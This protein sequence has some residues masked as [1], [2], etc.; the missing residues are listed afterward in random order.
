MDSIDIAFTTIIVILIIV[1]ISLIIILAQYFATLTPGR[2]LTDE[3]L[4][5]YFYKLQPKAADGLQE[6]LVRSYNLSGK[7]NQYSNY[8]LFR[9]FS[10]V[11]SVC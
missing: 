8:K 6:R 3:S 9:I 11:E 7:L 5:E 2:P 1:I 4:Y 10:G